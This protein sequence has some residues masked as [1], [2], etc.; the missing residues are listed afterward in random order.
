M[1]L[2]PPAAAVSVTAYPLS[3]PAS[4]GDSKSGGG[5]LNR[6]TPPAISKSSPSSPDSDHVTPSASSAELAL[7]AP[8][9]S[10][11]F[12]ARLTVAGPVTALS[13]SVTFWRVTTRSA[14]CVFEPSLTCTVTL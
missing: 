14:V 13:S 7:Y 4:P 8:T 10:A 1:T 6:S 9:R 2:L 12:S 11:A 5:S 3:A